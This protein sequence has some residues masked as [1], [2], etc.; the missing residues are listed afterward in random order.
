MQMNNDE[1]AF[2]ESKEVVNMRTMDLKEFVDLG[3]LQEL[4]RTYLHPMGLALA[5][6]IQDEK[7]FLSGILD[8][9]ED[10]EG[11]NFTEDALSYEKFL[12][13]KDLF[14]SKTKAREEKLGYF[15]QPVHQINK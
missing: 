9:R 12:K 3:I 1:E 14:L 7:Y 13:A 6:G 2:F 11:M 15:I 4:N 10:D 8:Y 5:V